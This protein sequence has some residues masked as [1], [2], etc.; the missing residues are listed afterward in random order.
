MQLSNIGHALDYKLSSYFQGETTKL[1]CYFFYISA[2][3]LSATCLCCGS[4]VVVA[5]LATIA[6]F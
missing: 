2:R 4:I 1:N 6:S 5:E 3:V